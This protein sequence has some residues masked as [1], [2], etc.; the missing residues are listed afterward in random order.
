M[1]A[2]LTQIVLRNTIWIGATTLWYG[3]NWLVPSK[4]DKM[5]MDLYKK[6]MEIN[7]KNNKLTDDLKTIKN[8]IREDLNIPEPINME[9][10][11]Y[12]IITN[13]EKMNASRE[14]KQ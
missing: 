13:I 9:E 3:W 7:E 2:L 6:I 11:V 4:K 12:V 1:I 8:M 14:I 10:Y 5:N